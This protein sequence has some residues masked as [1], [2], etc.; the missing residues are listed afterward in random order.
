MSDAKTKDEKPKAK[1]WED[2]KNEKDIY[3]YNFHKKCIH[4]IKGKLRREYFLDDGTPIAPDQFKDPAMWKVATCINNGWRA[5][6]KPNEVRNPLE[7]IEK[8]SQE[9]V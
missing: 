1:T 9:K 8:E 7:P 2:E 3:T 6:G 4:K 5:L